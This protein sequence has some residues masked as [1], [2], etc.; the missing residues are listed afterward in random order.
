MGDL[1]D[2]VSKAKSWY[3]SK[4]IIGVVLTFIPTIVKFISPESVLDIEGVINEGFQGAELIAQTGDQIWASA[5]EVFGVLLAIW[6]RI[7][8]KVVIR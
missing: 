6:G 1:Q 4:T 5:L 2:G 8:A 3:Q 7:K